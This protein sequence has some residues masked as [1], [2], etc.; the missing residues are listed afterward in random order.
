MKTISDDDGSNLQQK[1]ALLVSLA[2]GLLLA[3]IMVA[4][5]FFGDWS[6][7]TAGESS[8]D[9]SIQQ[10]ARPRTAITGAFPLKDNPALDY[11]LPTTF[12]A[13]YKVPHT[14]EGSPA[15]DHGLP[16]TFAEEMAR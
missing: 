13:D 7:K 2:G 5:G 14:P 11:S 8:Q 12:A 1:I 6:P 10:F 15:L 9:G 3:V 4:S 16:T